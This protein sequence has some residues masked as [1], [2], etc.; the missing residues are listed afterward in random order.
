MRHPTGLDDID[1]VIVG[2]WQLAEGHASRRDLAGMEVL[3]AYYR[4]GFRRFDCADIYTGVET[5]LGEFR[6]AH[7]LGE[8]ELAVHTKYVPDSS[9]L[10]TLTPEQTERAIDRSRSRL[11]VD[12]LELVQFHWW[13]TAVPG[14][15]A[16]LESLMAL[17][18]RGKIRAIG[19]TNFDSGLTAEIVGHGV[20]IASIQTQ[21]S[22]LD[23]RPARRLAAFAEAH[24]IPL[25]A[26]GSVAGGL[27]SDAHLGSEPP[28]EPHENRSLT[29]YLL[30]VEELGGWGALQ[31][32][33]RALRSVADAHGSDV[34]TVASAYAL[35]QRGVGAA[36]VGVRNVRH[37]ERHAALRSGFT[38]DQDELHTLEEVRARYPEVPGA[39]YALER[40]RDGPHGRIMRYDLQR[41][42]A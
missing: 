20:P 30:I 18:Q 23:R 15:L 27:L 3:E 40:D 8:D 21:I 24:G 26:Y 5:L 37:L 7:G 16:A 42:Q 31:A 11:G 17:Q 13:D 4:A 41:G 6:R 9:D 22:L 12:R 25:L 39:V 1:R 28:A 32:L 14:Y 35:A 34:A 38:L 2:C 33:L 10:A 36:I 19:L 29:K